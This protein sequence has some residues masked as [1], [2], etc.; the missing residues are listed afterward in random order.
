MIYDNKIISGK[1][2]SYRGVWKTK[3]SDAEK[4]AEKARVKGY[5]ARVIKTM[6]KFGGMKGKVGYLIYLRK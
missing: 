6:G 1:R 3:K 4:I 5:S 2:F